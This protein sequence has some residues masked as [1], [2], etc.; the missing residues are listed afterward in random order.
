VTEHCVPANLPSLPL[1]RCRVLDLTRALAGPYCTMILADLGADVIKVESAHGGD[2]TRSWGPFAG[3]ASVY[4]LSTNRNKRSIAIDLRTPSGLET[5]R[6]M[7]AQCDVLVENFKPPIA[8]EMGLGYKELS[9]NNPH[10]IYAS[11]SGF[12]RGGPYETWPGL[13]QIAQ[14][15]SG[16]MSVTGSAVSGPFRVGIPI[17]DLAAGMWAAIGVLSAMLFRR[18]SGVGQRVET[19]LLG[20]L[21][22]M[23]S[24]QGQRYLTLG[25]VATPTGNDHPV[26]A[27]YGAFETKNGFLNIAVATDAMWQDFCQIL[28]IDIA[29][30]PDYRD[31]AARMANRE[32]LKHLIE[33]RLRTGDKEHWAALLISAGIPAGPINRVDQAL[34]DRHVLDSGCIETVNHPT[35]GILRQL[36]SPIRFGSSSSPSS[37]TPPPILGEHTVEILQSFQFDDASIAELL[38]RGVVVDAKMAPAKR[39]EARVRSGPKEQPSNSV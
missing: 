11:I 24:V 9:A 38:R 21:I 7:A 27:P 23:L 15:V 12:G 22:G 31:N 26:I 3:E 20:S 28:E 4:F 5:V 6:R 36:A 8:E 25:E 2:I 32:T 19:S 30:H 10:L 13:D 37:R 1:A 34:E 33:T 17:A 14:G 16:L 39:E 18:T 35:L 29:Q